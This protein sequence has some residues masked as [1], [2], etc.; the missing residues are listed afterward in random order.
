MDLHTLNKPAILIPT[1]G[2]SEQEY[3]A[4]YHKSGSLFV[5]E[6][7]NNFDLKSA[8]IKLEKRKVQLF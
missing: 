8:I 2:Q 4:E 7:Q 5:F 1:P 6:S 3:L